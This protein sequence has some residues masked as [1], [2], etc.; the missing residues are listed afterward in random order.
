MRTYALARSPFCVLSILIAAQLIGHGQAHA[1]SATVSPLD[2]PVGSTGPL[3]GDPS[4]YI[5]GMCDLGS[6]RGDDIGSSSVV[7]ISSDGAVVAGNSPDNINAFRAFVWR[8]DGKGLQDLGTLRTDNT[9]VSSAYAVSADGGIVVGMASVDHNESSV[10]A[11]RWRDDGKGMLD[12]GTLRTDGSGNSAA[13]AISADG[14]TIGGVSQHNDDSSSSRAFLWRDGG[15]GMIDLGTLRSSNSGSSG[16]IAISAEGRTVVGNSSVNENS[17]DFRAFRW[18]D[19]GKGMVDLGSLR[20]DKLGSSRPTAISSDGSTIIGYADSDSR[21]SRAFRWRDDGEGMIDLGTLR[22][23]NSG[24]SI[25]FGIS[26]DGAIIVGGAESDESALYTRAFR[27]KDDG[28]GMLDLGTLRSDNTGYSAA[29]AVSADGSTIVGVAS[30]DAVFSRAFRWRDDGKGMLDL[31]TLRSDNSGQSSATHVSSDGRTIV[32]TA[33][34]DQ[35][36]F[37][38]F[39]WRTDMQ[40]LQNLMSSFPSLASD[41]ELVLAQQQDAHDF[42]SRQNCMV[43]QYRSCVRGTVAGSISDEDQG[44]DIGAQSSSVGVFSFGYGVNSALTVGGT[45]SL[46]TSDFDENG[47]ETEP[48]YAGTLWGRYSDGGLE[49][50]GL[51]GA[52][53]LTFGRAP[54]TSF[55]RGRGLE[56]VMLATGEADRDTGLAYVSVGYGFLAT[57]KLL[58]TPSLGLERSGTSI[59]GYSEDGGDFDVRYDDLSSNSTLAIASLS[60]EV[61]VMEGGSLAITAGVEHDLDADRIELR[62]VSDVPGMEEF[63]IGSTLERRSTRAFL[64]TQYKH[65]FGEHSDLTALIGVSQFEYG[66]VAD[67]WLGLGYGRRF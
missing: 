19:D 51:Q 27:W 31:G 35:G 60:L 26:S 23:D 66:D 43:H 40:D 7:G 56:N 55:T 62:G 47:V 41:I 53:A 2:C 57:E 1:Q 30:D 54:N 18:R 49:Q 37:R 44:E 42:V 8:N 10:R 22:A 28:R 3:P 48:A 50:T 59:D 46:S 36:V 45:V 12:L 34:T 20:S 17:F 65:R 38:A 21:R 13:T 4:P 33:E 52:A 29:S 58:I 11:F 64:S 32:G 61:S 67:L 24:F 25:A 9:G 15:N 63:E 6:L 5:G 14:G 16:V 39:I